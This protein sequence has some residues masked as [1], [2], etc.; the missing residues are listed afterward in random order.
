MFLLINTEQVNI[1]YPLQISFLS[2]FTTKYTMKRILQ[3][4]CLS[5]LMILVSQQKAFANNFSFLHWMYD[6]NII[7]AKAPNKIAKASKNTSWSKTLNI[8]NWISHK[9]IKKGLVAALG[10]GLFGLLYRKKL[11]NRMKTMSR[12]EKEFPWFGL[13][14][15]I[16]VLAGV[17]LLFNLWLGVAWKT[18]FLA[19]GAMLLLYF[20][21]SIT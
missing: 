14:S 18:L 13:I 5:F 20:F 19:A 21:F 12:Y 8:K 15:S 7:V 4:T 16:V 1:N 6:V 2:P 9:P 11:K 3:F 17:M 10:G